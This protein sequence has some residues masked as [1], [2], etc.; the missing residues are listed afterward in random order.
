M[1]FKKND[2]IAIVV[3]PKTHNGFIN[4]ND[5]Y[6]RYGDFREGSK[7]LVSKNILVYFDTQAENFRSFNLSNI[8][9]IT[10]LS[11]TPLE[12]NKKEQEKQEREK[13]KGI[14]CLS[15]KTR[16]RPDYL[17]Q[18]NDNYCGDC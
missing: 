15:C 14:N 2:K 7:F 13:M 6:N 11:R 8:V 17:N 5:Y 9:S 12:I 1:L 10:N 18:W 4:Q 16:L 3:K